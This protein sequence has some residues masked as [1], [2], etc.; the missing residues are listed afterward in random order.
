MPLRERKL[1]M[2]L[3]HAKQIYVRQT[4]C[5]LRFRRGLPIR[6]VLRSDRSLGLVTTLEALHLPGLAKEHRKIY[7][8]L[9]QVLNCR[10]RSDRGRA[11]AS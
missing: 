11:V 5:V 6:F 4:Q 9:Q 8:K 3:L 2:K 1:L 7:A 10:E